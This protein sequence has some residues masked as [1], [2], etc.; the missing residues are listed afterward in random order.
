VVVDAK[1][2]EALVREAELCA[3][4]E[5]LAAATRAVVGR[6]A[7]AFPAPGATGALAVLG[8]GPGAA[9]KLLATAD[10]LAS[11]KRHAEAA[12][13]YEEYLRRFPQGEDR[14]RV[15]AGASGQRERTGEGEAAAGHLARLGDVACAGVNPNGAALALDR[16]A[17]LYERA[18]R[19]GDA[20]AMREALVKLPGVTSSD[21]RNRVE[22]ARTRLEVGAAL[23]GKK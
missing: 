2:G 19:E 18:G 16:A 9:A 4:D 11:Q 13:A 6:V 23:D 21:A 22:G 3:G 17:T 12:A 14:C 1:K 15:L 10:G 7:N 8:A 20:T 5:G